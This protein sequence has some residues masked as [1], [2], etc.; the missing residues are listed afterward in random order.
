[1]SRDALSE[2]PLATPFDVDTEARSVATDTSRFSP[3]PSSSTVLSPDSE[4]TT[5]RS[6]TESDDDVTVAD[7]ACV[8][9]VDDT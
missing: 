7:C 3:V 9:E 5:I 6:V 2:S 4:L 8:V 1:M